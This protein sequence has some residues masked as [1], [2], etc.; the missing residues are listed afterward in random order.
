VR[1]TTTTLLNKHAYFSK[2]EV[3]FGGPR[4]QPRNL[5]REES[6]AAAAKLFNVILPIL[7]E[8]HWPDWEAIE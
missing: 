8:E 6:V 4:T 3:S 7:V 1:N 2:V 5:G